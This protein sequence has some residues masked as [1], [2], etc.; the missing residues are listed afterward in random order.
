MVYQAPD[1]LFD[2]VTSLGKAVPKTLLRS[3]NIKFDIPENSVPTFRVVSTTGDFQRSLFF[4]SLVQ[5]LENLNADPVEILKAFDDGYGSLTS[6]NDRTISTLQSIVHM[7]DDD[8][9]A[10]LMSRYGLLKLAANL[11]AANIGQNA[12]G[13]NSFLTLYLRSLSRWAMNKNLFAIPVPG[14]FSTLGLTDDFE[15]LVGKVEANLA[16]KDNPYEVIILANKKFVSGEVLIYRDPIIHIGDLKI[17]MALTED[18]IKKR[19][20]AKYVV[21]ANAVIESLSSMDNVIFFSQG[22]RPPL[23]NRLS[24]GDLD[25][26]RFEIIPKDGC[27]FWTPTLKDENSDDY[28]AEPDKSKGPQRLKDDFN[29][30]DLTTFIGQYIRQDCFDELQTTLTALADTRAL[31]LKDPDVMEFS[32]HISNAVDYAKSGVSV[33]LWKISQDPKFKVTAKPDILRARNLE[34]RYSHDGDYYQSTKLLGKIYQKGLAAREALAAIAR[35]AKLDNQPLAQQIDADCKKSSLSNGNLEEYTSKV[36]GDIR[37]FVEA[38]LAIHREYLK[39][40]NVAA[41]S[42]IDVFMTKPRDANFP[43]AHINSIVYFI[44]LTMVS[45]G[46]L[47]IELDP[48]RKAR[49]YSWKLAPGISADDTAVIFKQCAY[50]AW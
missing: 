22:D 29:I 23:P 32:T 33:D 27:K 48:D 8:R 9:D 50:E 13:E 43:E 16:Q 28:A 30:N 41:S 18:E 17:A 44:K 47:Q 11:G 39:G 14:S 36:R 21:D 24:G 3:S 40:R 31:G 6:I 26:D 1:R 15:I 25:G 2:S 35:P 10:E 12:F 4:E 5:A 19:L 20:A 49:G 45:A 46:A 38:K 34:L 37:V 42:E 7:T